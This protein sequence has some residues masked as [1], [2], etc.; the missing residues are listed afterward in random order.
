VSRKT[1]LSYGLYW[2][3]W[4]VVVGRSQTALIRETARS[5]PDTPE[6]HPSD[7][8]LWNSLLDLM[9]GTRDAVIHGTKK[10]VDGIVAGEENRN[11]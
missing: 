6:V 9:D 2:D 7:R 1:I 10:A 8:P 11:G 3:A 4:F 5:V